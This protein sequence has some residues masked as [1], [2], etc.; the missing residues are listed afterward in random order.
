M[1]PEERFEPI[2]RNVVQIV[3]V[4]R[5]QA[6]VQRAQARIERDQ[7]QAILEITGKLDALIGVVDKPARRNGH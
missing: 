6:D 2:A 4:Q 5:E 1:T 7:A 3:D